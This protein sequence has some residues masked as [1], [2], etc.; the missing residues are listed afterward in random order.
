MKE[1]LTE[2]IKRLTSVDENGCWNWLGNRSP[3]GYGES[4]V[5][6]LRRRAHRL[7]YEAFIGEIPPGAWVLHHCDN[8]A[9]CNPAHLYLGDHGRNVRDKVERERQAR[10]PGEMHPMSKLDEEAVRSIRMTSGARAP[11]ADKYGVSKQTISDIRSRRSW[12]H[13]P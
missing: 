5:G 1:P 2:R 12:K 4:S 7:S 11:L 6:G 10:F 3:K 8:P 13:L 9:C